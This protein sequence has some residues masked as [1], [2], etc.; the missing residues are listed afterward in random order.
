MGLAK[1]QLPQAGSPENSLLSQSAAID[2]LEE[3]LSI[4]PILAMIS[5]AAQ[6]KAIFR[7]GICLLS[8]A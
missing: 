1:V 4:L 2:L 5:A 8:Q 3:L 6:G 7:L